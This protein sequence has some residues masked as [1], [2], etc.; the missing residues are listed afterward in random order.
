MSAGM[1]ADPGPLGRGLYDSSLS[2]LHAPS[3][4]SVA[5]NASVP[6]NP[7]SASSPSA[8][9]TG[10]RLLLQHPLTPGHPNHPSHQS[11]QA[12]Q[13]SHRLPHHTHHSHLGHPGPPGHPHAHAHAHTAAPPP[14]HPH[15][16]TYMHAQLLPLPQQQPPQQQ[17]QLPHMHSS[18]LRHAG[19][20]Q[21]PNPGASSLRQ[22]HPQAYPPPHRPH[23]HHHHH[24][25]HQQQQQ[26]QQQQHMTQHQAQT[27]GHAHVGPSQA[28][29]STQHGQL[30]L[31][32]GHLTGGPHAA[33]SAPA[34]GL[35]GSDGANSLLLP[36]ADSLH[37]ALAAQQRQIVFAGQ[38][39]G[40][41]A[42]PHFPF[43]TIF[44]LDKEREEGR[45]R[46]FSLLLV[47]PTSAFRHPKEAAEWNT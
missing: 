19:F 46:L 31:Q 43:G 18:Q 3:A 8:S 42:L 41:T 33:A 40:E 2:Q 5:P 16:H 44:C 1:L 39:A 17:Q 47:P 11:L 27:M 4:V 21:S 12:A 37:H 9:L 20:P 22:S 15:L 30:G 34:F 28:Q 35:A 14:P 10:I 13:Q 36:A 26:Q 25:L 7:S 45:A 6:A 24:H 23:L 29:T 32:P 38:S